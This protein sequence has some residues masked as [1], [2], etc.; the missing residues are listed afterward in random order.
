MTARLFERDRICIFENGV[1]SMNL[2]PVAQVVGARATRTTHPQVLAGFRRLLAEVLG[3]PFD[4]Q[5]PFTWFTKSEVIERISANGCGDLIRATRSCT[6]VHDMT[7]LHPHCGQCSQCVGRRF[8][9]LAAQ[10]QHEDPPEA[11]KVDLFLGARPAG[12]DR[13]IALAFV[14]SASIVNEMADVAFFAHYGEAS[15]IVGFFPESG[16]AVA[17]SIFE[18][19]KRHA[20][21]VC[22]IFDDAISAHRSDLR[23]GILQPD[24]LLSLVMSQR[25]GL[26]IYSERRTTA[27]QVVAKDS[28]IRIAIDEEHKLVVLGGWGKIKG[29]SAE[30]IIALAQPFRQAMQDELAPEHYPFVETSKLLRLTNCDVDET[31][32]RRVLRCRNNIERLATRAGDPPPSMSD[33][34]ENSQRHGYRL[35]P[36]RIR[37]VAISELTHTK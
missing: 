16:D 2:P 37:I 28:E 11:Y 1:V 36:D 25:D 10:Q 19:H 29:V 21:S 17:N 32:R 35:N 13:E 27:E 7:N 23:K 12:P 34:I 18:L 8:A 4:I 31:L 26:R 3:C 33:V 20:S 22:N 24:C 5:N 9:V 15:R 30:L 6:R 14:R